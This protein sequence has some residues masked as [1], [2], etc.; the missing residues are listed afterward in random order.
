L[1]ILKKIPAD[2]R[3]CDSSKEPI[4]DTASVGEVLG[5]RSR[6]EGPL[7][8]EKYSAE[9]ETAEVTTTESS[10]SD[11]LIDKCLTKAARR[12]GGLTAV[13]LRRLAPGRAR[14]EIVDDITVITVDISLYVTKMLSMVQ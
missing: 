3:V 6:T 4:I 5:K 7:E 13:E 2:T 11:M 14:R 12:K 10:I 8:T 9:G 1:D